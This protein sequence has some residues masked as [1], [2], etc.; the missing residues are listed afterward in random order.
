MLPRDTLSAPI[1]Q[2]QTRIQSMVILVVS[3]FSTIGAAWMMLSYFV[4]LP[5]DG[6]YLQYMESRNAVPKNK[7]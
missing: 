6:G 5:A 7:V 1:A 2:E 3:I 4:S